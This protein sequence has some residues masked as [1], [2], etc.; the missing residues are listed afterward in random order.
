MT[1][2]QF[3]P[4]TLALGFVLLGNGTLPTA[5]AEPILLNSLARLQQTPPAS[6]DAFDFVVTGDTHSNRQLVYQTDLFKGM[7]REWN[8]LQPAF[9]L[10][11]GDLVLGGSANNV[12][13]QWDLFEKTIAECRVPY[14]S[15]PGNHDISDALSERLWQERMGRSSC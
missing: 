14:L 3:L 15:A 6:P 9:A 10:E 1:P 5:T 7:I 4:S 11:V 2:L 12:P 8:L 13:P